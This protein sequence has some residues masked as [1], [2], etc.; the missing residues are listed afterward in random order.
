MNVYAPIPFACDFVARAKTQIENATRGFKSQLSAE[1]HASPRK[2]N[3]DR[4]HK[5][6]GDLT[7]FSESSDK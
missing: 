1:L 3:T 2:S 5:S 7:G 4:P 6:V